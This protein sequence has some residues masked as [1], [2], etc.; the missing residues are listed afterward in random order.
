MSRSTSSL[1]I[2]GGGSAGWITALYLQQYFNKSGQKI[3]ISLIESPQQGP[4]GVGEATVHSIRFLFAA[5]G[6]DERELMRETNATL[7]LGIMFNNWMKPTAKGMHQYFHPFEQQQLSTC[8]TGHT[9]ST[10]NFVQGL[11]RSVSPL[12]IGQTGAQR[13]RC[14]T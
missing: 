14:T 3:A 8:P 6:L 1:L 4:I 11:T 9:V 2:V 5:L 7:K 13:R 10:G 12:A